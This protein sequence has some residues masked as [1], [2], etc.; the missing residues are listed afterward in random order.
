[1]STFVFVRDRQIHNAHHL[2]DNNETQKSTKSNQQKEPILRDYKLI[3]IKL[4]LENASVL[5][6]S[7][8]V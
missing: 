6:K 7:I 4:T 8:V 5:Q 3:E 1:M 2:I